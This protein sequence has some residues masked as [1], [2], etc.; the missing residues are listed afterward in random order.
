MPVCGGKRATRTVRHSLVS[1]RTKRL[2]ARAKRKTWLESV[3]TS[4]E[5]KETLNYIKERKGSRKSDNTVS[6]ITLLASIQTLLMQR[7]EKLW[8]SLVSH[9]C[10]KRG[11]NAPSSLLSNRKVI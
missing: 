8:A 6:A 3:Q 11:G 10:A 1:A 7:L 2:N 4:E 5:I 9:K